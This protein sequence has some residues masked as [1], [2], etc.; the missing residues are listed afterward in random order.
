[1]EFGDLSGFLLGC[2]IKTEDLHQFAK[3]GVSVPF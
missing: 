1:M 2:A 3:P